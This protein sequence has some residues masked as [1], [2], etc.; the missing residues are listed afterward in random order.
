MA[1]V[2]L[3]LEA[4]RMECRGNPLDLGAQELA[5]DRVCVLLFVMSVLLRGLCSGGSQN[6]WERRPRD[7]KWV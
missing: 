1:E 5:V 2:V 6:G 3:D 4:G 7:R